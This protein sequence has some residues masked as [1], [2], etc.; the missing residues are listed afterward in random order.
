[1]QKWEYNTIKQAREFKGTLGGNLEEWH[2]QIDLTMLGKDGWELVAVVPESSRD[3]QIF[4]GTTTNLMWVF[5]R[6]AA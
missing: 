1:M 4:A 3:G 6:P 5:K 2:P